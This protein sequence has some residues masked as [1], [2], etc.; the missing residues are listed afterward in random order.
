MKEREGRTYRG[1]RREGVGRKEKKF[2]FSFF[3]RIDP[4]GFLISCTLFVFWFFVAFLVISGD[5]LFLL[6]RI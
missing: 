4:F 1:D 2:V 6:L 3:A 5:L